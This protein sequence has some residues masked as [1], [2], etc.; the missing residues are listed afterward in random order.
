M[1]Y[2]YLSHITHHGKLTDIFMVNRNCVIIN[3]ING[4]RTVFP[5]RNSAVGHEDEQGR[6]YIAPRIRNLGKVASA[7]PDTRLFSYRYRI[8]I[9]L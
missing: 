8:A 2:V 4:K 1:K 9:N 7:T 6:R 3:Q 5:A